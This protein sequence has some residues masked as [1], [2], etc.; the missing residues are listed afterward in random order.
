MKKLSKSLIFIFVAYLFLDLSSFSYAAI[1]QGYQTDA[2]LAPG[3]IVSIDR[4]RV[5]FVIK[6]NSDNAE[7]VLGVVSSEEGALLQMPSEGSNVE[8]IT[9]GEAD[10]LVTDIDGAIRAGDKITPSPISGAGMR[11]ISA[12]R[13]IAVALEGFSSDIEGAQGVTIQDAS[14]NDKNISVGIIRAQI[15]VHD[16]IPQSEGK[17]IVFVTLQEA[18]QAI[19][20]RNV[21]VAKALIAAGIMLSTLIVVVMLLAGAIQGSMLSL[22]RNP[23]AK[24]TIFSTLF[25]FIALS[26]GIFVGGVFVAYFILVS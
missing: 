9:S 21:S 26:T 13:V 7:D 23:L 17:N 22:G 25:K 8:V 3:H 19:T 2:E 5:N 14:G 10:I 6:A 18:A 20:G 16:Y 24:K 1:S 4:D 12:S 11:A 15:G